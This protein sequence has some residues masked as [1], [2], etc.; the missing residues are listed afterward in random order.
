MTLQ[1]LR[2]RLWWALP[3]LHIE[4]LRQSWLINFP[5]FIAV[6]SWFMGSQQ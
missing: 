3:T 1:R 6:G 5:L 2:L 4:V